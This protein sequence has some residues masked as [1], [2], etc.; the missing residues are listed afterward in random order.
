M[1]KI[2]NTIERELALTDFVVNKLSERLLIM[3]FNGY[4]PSE[5]SAKVDGRYQI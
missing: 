4:A 2:V 3:E 5:K 1:L